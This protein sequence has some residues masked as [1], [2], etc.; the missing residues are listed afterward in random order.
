MAH[1]V[2]PTLNY[3]TVRKLE[4]VAKQRESFQKCKSEILNAVKAQPRPEEKLQ[5]LIDTY[6][7]S[8]IGVRLNFNSPKNLKIF[9]EQA[10]DDASISSTSIN[11]W[12]LEFEQELDI[13]GA[14]Y[15]YACLF[16]QLVTEATDNSNAEESKLRSLDAADAED[17][18]SSGDT[19]SNVSFMEVG[20]QEMHD[21]RREWEQYSFLQRLTDQKAIEKYLD[22]LFGGTTKAKKLVK[23]PLQN[24][25]ESFHKFDDNVKLG[26]NV[27]VLNECI[28]GVL[29]SGLFIGA[30]R[31]AL[32]ELK[33]RD[34]A[35]SEIADVLNM[36]LNT[37]DSW[38]WSTSP[39]TLTMRKQLN[40]KYRVFMDEEIYEALFLH[41]IGAHWAVHMKDTFKRFFHSGAWL[42]TN[43]KTMSKRDRARRSYFLA[44]AMTNSYGEDNDV[45]NIRRRMYQ[46]D[47]FMTQLPSSVKESPREYANMEWESDSEVREKS[48]LEIKQKLLHLATTEMLLNT[49][50]YGQFTI[51]QSDFKWFGPSLPHSTIFA[52]LKFFG[53][54]EKWITFFQ[55]FLQAPL[56]FA[57]D[58]V[59]AEPQTRVRGLP[60]SHVLADAL[61]EA[62]LFC[63]DFAVNKRTQ[64]SLYRFHDDLWFWGQQSVCANAWEAMQEFGNIMGLELNEE[65]TGAATISA[66]DTENSKA[67]S[68]VGS[69]GLPV[70]TVRWGFLM[71]DAK[72]G[73]W[74]IDQ[75]QV[76]DHI[77]ELKRQLDSFDSVLGWVH[78]WN[79]YVAKFFTTNFGKAANC[80][81]RQHVQMVIETFKKIQCNLFASMEPTSTNV[82]EYLRNRIEDKFDV[83]GVPDGFFYLPTEFGGLELHNPFIPLLAIKAS[84]FRSSAERIER[85]FEEDD[86]DYDKAKETFNTGHRGSSSLNV[87][88]SH[89][90]EDEPFMSREEFTRFR[91]Q[92]SRNLGRAYENLLESPPQLSVE[93]SPD[94]AHIYENSVGKVDGTLAKK[95]VKRYWSDLSSYWKWMTSMLAQDMVEKFGG[96]RMSDQGLL[97]TGM[98]SVLQ[99]NKVN[100]KG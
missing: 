4:K 12:L 18:S 71:L 82:I 55:K 35:L 90:S 95:G 3:V 26:F 46:D 34:A 50:L 9:L 89:I 59:N 15:D 84:S 37:L 7:K 39:I 75:Q 58:G 67:V 14:K 51:L 98:V 100:W 45:R 70:G 88:S 56:V 99:S 85:S 62:V 22:E 38:N 61:G 10:R 65:K 81:G 94:V 2:L 54:P 28:D 48:P 74:V 83:T 1:A 69:G 6:E 27:S 86:A 21:Q 87:R 33:G 91:E 79:S 72:L 53:V 25:R 43:F 97:A 16:G 47:F 30:K 80:M 93:Q 32:A 19:D 24:L 23:T 78:A 20:R 5:A 42:Q 31:A 44:D 92:T 11:K 60:M 29:T 13:Q 41:H 66:P 77:K 57:Q 73:R 76:D 36:E 64:G 17:V 49:K 96:F 63:L 8:Q 52:V 68:S 40:G